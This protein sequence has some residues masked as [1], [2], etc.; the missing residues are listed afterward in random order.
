LSVLNVVLTA[1]SRITQLPLGNVVSSV[2]LL[3][4]LLGGLSAL[5]QLAS[6]PVSGQFSAALSGLTL[7]GPGGLTQLLNSIL[8]FLGSLLTS[9]PKLLAGVP[10]GSI[11]SGLPDLNGLLGGVSNVG[12][13]TGAA[14]CQCPTN[15]NIGG[16]L[17][18]S[19]GSSPQCNCGQIID[20]H[21]NQIN[22]VKIVIA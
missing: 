12:T 17:Q 1:I 13:G 19:S 18:P 10:L 4:S 3:G 8:S 16:S 7:S 22:G 20:F 15:S 5:P 9:I 14:G 11:L 21:D 2:P 6:V